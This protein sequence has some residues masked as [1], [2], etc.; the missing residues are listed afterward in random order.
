MLN[1]RL[2]DGVRSEA[3]SCH[4]PVSSTSPKLP[5][6][7]SFP[8][9]F[10]SSAG[11]AGSRGWRLSGWAAGSHPGEVKGQRFVP[12]KLN[13]IG[14][15][16][17]RPFI[18]FKPAPLPAA[19]WRGLSVPPVAMPTVVSSISFDFCIGPADSDSVR[20]TCVSY[21]RACNH[22]NRDTGGLN[23]HQLN[24]SSACLRALSWPRSLC[25]VMNQHGGFFPLYFIHPSFV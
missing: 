23:G 9:I 25:H 3:S 22:G 12:V 13:G 20:F 24:A 7:T 2:F 17:G 1:C 15:V 6:A 14:D 16:T 11:L 19:L 4:S 5:A 18:R 10:L 8:S 21:Y